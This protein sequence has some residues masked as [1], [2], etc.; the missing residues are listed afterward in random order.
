MTITEIDQLIEEGLSLKQITQAYS[1]L[2]HLKIKRIR[3][4]AERNRIFFEEIFY[5]YSLV[6]TEAIKK[7]LVF[8][9]AKK[10]VSLILTS[11]YRFYGNINSTLIDFYLASTSG[12]ETDRIILGKAAIDYFRARRIFANYQEVLLKDDQPQAAELNH[13][14][15]L[16]KDYQQVLVFYSRL[17]SLLVQEPAVVDITATSGAKISKTYFQHQPVIPKFE[18]GIYRA[19]GSSKPSHQIGIRF[20]FE[21][22]LHQ[23]LT[24]FDHQILILLLEQTFLESEVSRTASRFISMDQAEIAANKFIKQ[25]EA[26]KAHSLKTLS[27]TKLLEA[28]AALKQVSS[29]P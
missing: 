18:Q 2:A 13:L 25:Y 11:N 6:K 7:R 27:N 5:V 9:K 8:P 10:R 16:I 22:Q 12:I 23:I 19:S 26:V 3:A 17:K 28:I 24:F 21:P 20:L 29:R 14:T 4:E 1:E 15:A